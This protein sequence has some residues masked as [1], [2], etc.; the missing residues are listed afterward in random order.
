M[1][2][3]TPPVSDASSE[4]DCPADVLDIG[5][6]KPGG[7]CRQHSHAERPI[8]RRD[9]SIIVVQASRPHITLHIT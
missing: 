1:D 2:H 9:A 5:Q 8:T 7:L 3:V 6:A 4:P